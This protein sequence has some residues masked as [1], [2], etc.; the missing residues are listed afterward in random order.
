MQL[1]WRKRSFWK[2]M[3]AAQSQYAHRSD[4]SSCQK[5]PSICRVAASKNM[6]RYAK[7]NIWCCTTAA[8]KVGSQ[9]VSVSRWYDLSLY[10][11][12]V[13]EFTIRTIPG[14]PGTLSRVCHFV[15]LHQAVEFLRRHKPQ[16]HRLFLQRCAMGMGRFGNFRGVIIADFRRECCDQH[17]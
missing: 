9:I 14:N 2:K 10:R 1:V 16:P 6:F 15:R 4:R 11:L 3:C 13:N 17:Q 7:T 5:V 8:D 12:A